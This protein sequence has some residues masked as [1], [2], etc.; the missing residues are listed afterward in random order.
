MYSTLSFQDTKKLGRQSQL[1]GT[2]D[3]RLFSR[4]LIIRDHHGR[5]Y[6]IDTGSE[7]SALPATSTHRKRGVFGRLYAANGSAINTYGE[8]LVHVD[9]R[10]RRQFPWIFILA[11]VTMPI[12]GADF[13]QHF[14]LTVDMK[15]QRL[16]DPETTLA[17]VGRQPPPEEVPVLFSITPTPPTPDLP[18]PSQEPAPT[19]PESPASSPR[20]DHDTGHPS[21]A[22]RQPRQQTRSGR[23]VRFPSHLQSFVFSTSP[24][25]RLGGGG[26][27]REYCG[28]PA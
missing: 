11:D 1:A 21:P 18:A 3:E 28:S 27:G 16:T 22:L 26:G 14:G 19:S 25:A 24:A 23:R 15:N 20:P 5:S 2:A 9:L 4:R 7:I 6:L 8:E 17:A 13:L 10:L 12:I